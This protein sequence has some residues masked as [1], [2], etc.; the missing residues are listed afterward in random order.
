[1]SVY[2][3]LFLGYEIMSVCEGIVSVLQQIP[4]VVV[5]T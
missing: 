2:I 4:F 5:R 3:Q 1:M